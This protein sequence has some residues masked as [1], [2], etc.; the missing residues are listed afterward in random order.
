MIIWKNPSNCEFAAWIDD[1]IL[2]SIQASQKNLVVLDD[3]MTSVGESKQI[4]KIFTPKA[5]HR[6]LTVNF[7]VQNLFS[8]WREMRTV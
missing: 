4:S 8:H 6:N 1:G 2:G 5:H 3:L 7:I